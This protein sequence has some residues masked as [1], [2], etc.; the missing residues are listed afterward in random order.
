MIISSIQS[1]WLKVRKRPMT[2]W[3]IG[4]M[5]TLAFLYPIWT[6]ALS[7]SLVVDTSHGL[8]IMAGPGGTMSPEALVAAEQL[9]EKVALPYSSF[10][11][12]GFI[13][14]LGRILM[15]VLG[16]SLAGS[17]FSWGT[18]RHLIGRTRNRASYI[19]GKLIVLT[20]IALALSVGIAVSGAL[21]GAL[22][23]PSVLDGAEAAS[24]TIDFMMQLLLGMFG[25]MLTFL[26]YALFAFFIA[27]TTRSSV[28]AVGIGLVMLMIGEPVMAQIFLA[29]G[30]PWSEITDFLPYISIQGIKELLAASY[31]GIYPENIGRTLIVLMGNA[32]ALAGLAY[33]S[34]SK[35]EFTA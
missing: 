16:A 28:A 31:T 5:L 19:I 18:A 30:S 9:R 27:L 8:R 3:I 26:P 29:L 14:G 7:R 10:T 24:F 20:V 25:T 32:M 33:A 2:F 15:V 12:L 23:T 35:K 22:V 4:I 13:A 11:T 34:F 21:G 6:V 17:E 1:E